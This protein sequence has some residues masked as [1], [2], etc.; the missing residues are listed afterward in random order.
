LVN[1]RI[2]DGRLLFSWTDDSSDG[3][4]KMELAITADGH[5]ELRFLSTPDNVKINPLKLA[6]KD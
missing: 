5:S 2:E 3:P 6:R 4:M 1:P